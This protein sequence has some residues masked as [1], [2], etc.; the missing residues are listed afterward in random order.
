MKYLS[1]LIQVKLK[2]LLLFTCNALMHI[3]LSYLTKTLFI[4]SV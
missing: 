2:L 4:G 3:T 1:R